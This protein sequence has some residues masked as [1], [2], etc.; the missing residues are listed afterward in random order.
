MEASHGHGGGSYGMHGL[1]LLLLLLGSHHNT[2][3]E[4][5]GVVWIV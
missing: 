5:V 4:S 2:M 1:L 3:G